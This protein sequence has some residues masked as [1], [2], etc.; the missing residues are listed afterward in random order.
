MPALRVQI[1]QVLP[2]AQDYVL[3]WL[4]RHGAEVRLNCNVKSLGMLSDSVELEGGEIF[5]GHVVQC[6]GAK[7]ELCSNLRR[8]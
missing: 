3:R 6:F 8:I 7:A 2:A 5:E 4:E 1:P